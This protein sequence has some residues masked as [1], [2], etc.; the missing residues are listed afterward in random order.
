MSL[1]SEA[2]GHDNMQ[3]HAGKAAVADVPADHPAKDTPVTML[4]EC[5][6]YTNSSCR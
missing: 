4:H 1:I 2:C 3:G 5:D 6:F